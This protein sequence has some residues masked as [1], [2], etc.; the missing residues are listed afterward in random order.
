METSEPEPSSTQPK[1]FADLSLKPQVLRAVQ[2]AGYDTPTTIQSKIIPPIL[3]G[4]DVLA[5]S[6]T[7]TGKT[8]AFALPILSLL[9]VERRSPQALVL[10][11]TRELA[12]QVAKSFTT[13][14][15]AL[16]K[17]SVAAIYGG[18][19]YEPQFKQ[20][21]RGVQVIVGT[22]GR[23]ID[24]I[25][26]GTLNLGDIDYFVLDEADRMLDMGFHEDVQFMLQHMPEQRQI[27]LFSA[28]MPGPIVN[29]AKRYLNDPIRVTIESQSTAA[30]IRQRALFVAPRDKLRLLAQLLEVEDT[31]GV[32]VFVRTKEATAVVA[33]ELSR[34]GRTTVALNGD[35]SQ[36]ARD[37]A[38]ER[39]RGGYLDILVATDVAARGL[40]VTRVS[41]VINFDIP[42]T[43]DAYT[44]R[45]GRTGRAE[46]SGKAYTFVTHEDF[47]S[48][49][50]IERALGME[51][52]RVKLRDFA[53]SMPNERVSERRPPS[54]KG[55]APGGRG[56][57]GGRGRSSEGSRGGG[58]GGGRGGQRASTASVRRVERP[59]AAESSGPGFGA[60]LDT[61]GGGRSQGGAPRKSNKG[62]GGLS[63]SGR[64]RKRMRQ[65][66]SSGGS[67]QGAGPRGSGGRNSRRS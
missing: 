2:A 13:Y 48:I 22:P 35:M 44:H 28:T 62:G 36:R 26:R 27:A 55:G 50:A 49:K 9:D 5:Q 47:P 56:E 14:A 6:Q 58:G 46:S 21:K 57:R 30:L 25:K 12:I 60:G 59:A 15:G 10:T 32:I 7:G 11:P 54:R 40:D 31:D 39:F 17:F 64:R 23:V 41:H 45:I 34:Q 61:S 33:E 53:G 1:G 42:N 67:G 8:A 19:D 66:G 52:P 65:S 20:L 16:P 29:I 63:K 24:H 38:V 3:A 51:I 37:R 18:Q 4:R 43:P